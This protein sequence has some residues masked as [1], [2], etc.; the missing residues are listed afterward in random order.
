[1]HAGGVSQLTK[2]NPDLVAFSETMKMDFSPGFFNNLIGFGNFAWNS[3]PDTV[4][5]VV[6]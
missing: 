5:L 2:L 4:R 3:L 1:M 6:S